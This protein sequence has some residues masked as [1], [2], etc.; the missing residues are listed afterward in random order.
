[1]NRKKQLPHGT[2]HIQNINTKCIQYII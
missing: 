1:M 2:V